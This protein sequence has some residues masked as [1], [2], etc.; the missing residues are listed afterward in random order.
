MKIL[1]WKNQEYGARLYV[2]ILKNQNLWQRL[3]ECAS[4]YYKPKSKP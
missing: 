3:I 4:I 2:G 1:T